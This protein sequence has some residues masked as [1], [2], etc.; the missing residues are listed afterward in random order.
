MKIEDVSEEVLELIGQWVCE[1]SVLVGA[2]DVE[3]AGGG[4]TCD[5]RTVPHARCEMKRN[6]RM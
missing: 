2:E 1:V 3:D 5:V 6:C 4:C